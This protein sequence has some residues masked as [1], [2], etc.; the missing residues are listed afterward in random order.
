MAKE[1]TEELQ[2]KKP[3]YEIHT[4]NVEDEKNIIADQ[5]TGQIQG[6]MLNANAHG[7][8]NKE[9]A[10]HQDQKEADEENA[11]K[12]VNLNMPKIAGEELEIPIRE[13]LNIIQN[14]NENEDEEQKEAEGNRFTLRLVPRENEEQEPVNEEN[15]LIQVNAGEQDKN[16]HSRYFMDMINAEKAG[17]FRRDKIDHYKLKKIPDNETLGKE[18]GKTFKERLDERERAAKQKN[19]KSRLYQKAENAKLLTETI[20][21]YDTESYDALNA[22]IT[23]QAFRVDKEDYQDLSSFMIPGEE[24]ANRSLVNLYLGKSV[25]QAGNAF[26]G[27]NTRKALDTMASRLF[28]V[29][30]SDIDL[31]N[32]TELVNNAA[33]LESLSGQVAA[34]ERMAAKHRYMESLNDEAGAQLRERLSALRSIAAYYQVRKDIITNKTYMTHY[35]DELSMDVGAAGE[36]EKRELAQKLMQSMVLGHTMMSF[37]GVRVNKKTFGTNIK[38]SSDEM[39]DYHAYVQDSYFKTNRHRLIL[40]DASAQ[41]SKLAGAE[42]LRLMTRLNELNAIN[43][44]EEQE[45]IG[46]QMHQVQDKAF[47]PVQAPAD[48]KMGWASW[49]KNRVMLGWRWFAGLP[50]HYIIDNALAKATGT[51][52]MLLESSRRKTAQDKRRH[53]MV[54]GRE[55]ETF[56]EE[57]IRKDANGEDIDIYSDTRRGPLVWEKLTAGDPEDPPEVI[58]MMKQSKRGSSVS[59]SG[60][61]MGHAMIALSYS[62]YNKATKRKERYQL[63]MGFNPGGGLVRDTTF[64]MVTGALIGGQLSEED[65]TA[66]YDVSRRYQVKPGDINK[67]LREAEKYA[68]KG[69][70][71]YKRNCTTF[72]VDMA[73]TINLPIADEFKE[74]EMVFKG[75]NRFEVESVRGTAGSGVMYMGANAISSRMNKMD[76]SYQN[77]GQKMYTKED[78]DRFYKTSGTA[79]LLPKGYSPG[80]AGEVLRNDSRGELGAKYKEHAKLDTVEL[81]NQLEKDMPALLD[82]SINKIPENQRTEVDYEA[83]G[84]VFDIIE[85]G[86]FDLLEDDAKVTPEKCRNCYKET[87]KNMQTVRSYYAVLMKTDPVV[88]D[89]VMK[90][91]SLAE[92]SLSFIDDLYVKCLDKDTKGDAGKLRHNFINTKEEIKYVDEKKITHTAYV[93]PGVLEGYL[94]AGKTVAEAVLELERIDQINEADKRE[95]DAKNAEADGEQVEDFEPRSRSQKRADNKALAK[96]RRTNSLAVDFAR[97]NRYLLEKEDFTE[98]DLEYA[99]YKL[100]SMERDTKEKGHIHLR[101]L[102][103]FAP[104]VTYQG[105]IFEKLFGGIWELELDKTAGTSFKKAAEDLEKYMSDRIKANTELFDRI[106]K[107]FVKV[108]LEGGNKDWK[109]DEN[110]K[111]QKIRDLAGAFYYKLETCCVSPFYKGRLSRGE[112]SA[113]MVELE[114]NRGPLW[115]LINDAVKRELDAA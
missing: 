90:C 55:G 21:K 96:L 74:E 58:I 7:Y 89:L 26:L 78:L 82:A 108:K 34:F 112:L 79:E 32:D 20:K 29:D 5:K 63:K 3:V 99:F 36:D 51:Q 62:R 28:A 104:S 27:Q 93:T 102:E 115:E 103:E 111:N 65:D 45:E 1:K 101:Y 80:A 57:I 50:L 15:N 49:I 24:A 83:R 76:L 2:I 25:R 66:A 75:R 43:P 60:P 9:K 87:R 46:Q 23:R 114:T 68:D 14:E 107:Y 86:L 73:K 22:V 85:C 61:D 110:R 67:I 42:L 13:N 113:V 33:K 72:V 11:R 69:Y 6:D 18:Y 64:A 81:K 37:N 10:D 71:Y 53:D 59:L 92:V 40:E 12:T 106:I 8:E 31:S 97:A 39:K 105:V 4:E 88:N 98:K 38:Y 30:V 94:M 48:K 70:G 95:T 84:A 56:R 41:K 100:P 109:T 16:A 19:K 47:V 54:P 77:F 17:L 35:N 52:A 44:I 91:L